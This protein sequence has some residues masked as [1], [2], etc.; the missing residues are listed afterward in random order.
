[1]VPILVGSFHHFVMNGGHPDEDER[2]TAVIDTLRKE[3]AGRRVLAVASVDLAHVGPNFGDGFKMDRQRRIDLKLQDEALMSTAVAG[4]AAGWYARIA[5]VQDRN[6]ICGFAP[7]YLLLRYLEAS[8]GQV[9]AYDQ[10][11]ADPQD[12]SLV[13]ICGLLLD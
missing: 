7:T 9:I 13:S 3:T 12:D 4:D 1:M 10:C 11:P 8:S 6:R 5:A 2:L